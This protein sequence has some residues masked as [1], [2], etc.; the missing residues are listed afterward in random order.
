MIFFAAARQD[1]T[2]RDVDSWLRRKFE[3]RLRDIE[4]VQKE[5]LD[6]VGGGRTF[7]RARQLRTRAAAAAGLLP[8]LSG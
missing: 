8:R 4:V 6:L 3:G 7:Q 5:D 2:E 1:G